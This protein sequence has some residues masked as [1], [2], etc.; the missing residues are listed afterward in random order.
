MRGFRF[1]ILDLG[2]VT[3]TKG[4][5][6]YA[7]SSGHTDAFLSCFTFQL[8]VFFELMKLHGPTFGAKVG[9]SYQVTV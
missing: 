9:V 7:R 3:L 5:D 4:N 2:L 6:A 1:S 8:V